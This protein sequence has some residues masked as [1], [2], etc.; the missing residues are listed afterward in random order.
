MYLLGGEFSIITS[1]N[2]SMRWRDQVRFLPAHVSKP[3]RQPSAARRRLLCRKHP[4]LQSRFDR[5]L[6]LENRSS[7][8]RSGNR[9]GSLR[10]S[11]NREFRDWFAA[12]AGAGFARQPTVVLRCRF[13]SSCS[14]SSREFSIFTA[15]MFAMSATSRRSDCVNVRR[16][17]RLSM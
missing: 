15:A 17:M 13:F 10:R 9:S 2:C 3:G 4:Q 11:G 6:L 8:R 5:V 1:F 14:S 16:E 7:R 12:A